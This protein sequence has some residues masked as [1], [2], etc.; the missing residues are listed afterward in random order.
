M[1]EERVIVPLCD[2]RNCPRYLVV[3]PLAEMVTKPNC[4][5]N[6]DPHKGCDHYR[7]KHR[8]DD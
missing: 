1:S 7:F 4:E 3:P 6:R 2:V 8:K 5:I